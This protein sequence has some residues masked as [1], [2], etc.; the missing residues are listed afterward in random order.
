MPNYYSAGV[1]TNEQDRS[2]VAT[3]ASTSIAAIAVYA[4]QGPINEAV[5]VTNTQDYISKFGKP[6]TTNGYSAYAALMFLERS[7]ALYVTRVVGGSYA[8]AGNIITIGTGGSDGVITANTGVGSAT[9]TTFNAFTSAI[10][11]Y[12]YA[13]GPGAIGNNLRFDIQS[14]NLPV[15]TGI[16]STTTTTGGTLATGTK[17]YRVS[18]VGP[19]G[20]TLASTAHVTA[21]LTTAT[22][23]VTLTIPNIPN[24]VGYR[25]YGRTAGSES[26]LTTVSASTGSNTE[27]L[28]YD[29][30][31][32]PVAPLA[33][34]IV[35]YTRSDIFNI[36]VFDSVVSSSTPVESFEVSL[37]KQVDGYGVQIYAETRVN[38]ESNYVRIATNPLYTG[39][40]YFYPT[41][42]STLY[43]FSGGNDGSAYSSLTDGNYST[44]LNVFRD[45]EQLD[46]NILIEGGRGSTGYQQELVKLASSRKDCFAILDVP[47]A[48]QSAVKA[49][50]Y[51][52][53]T[54]ATNNN[55]AGL[56]TPDV[57]IS[58]VYGN[59][60][61]LYVPPSGH[62][63]GV[64]A[65]T[66]AVAETWF[67]P[68]GLNRGNL[69]VL[70]VRYKYNQA[71]RDMLAKAQINMIRAM[72]GLGIAV[73]GDSTLQT[74]LSAFSYVGVR[75]MFDFIAKT[76][77]QAL[78]FSVFEP[79]DS[80]L[81]ASIT[82]LVSNILSGIQ[83]KRGISDY[84]VV[85]NP[86]PAQ[87]AQG[88][89][90]VDVY[91]RPV[92]STRVI[93]VTLVATA[94]GVSVSEAITG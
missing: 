55:R 26:Y 73:W 83:S 89:L 60:G 76:A 45:P 54:L 1:Y 15:P 51:R 40:K 93:A 30:S 24:A 12:V 44:A 4:Q 79:N 33:T 36:R 39:V 25:I 27:F 52:T 32:T 67:S 28:D 84:Q 53:L 3:P 78:Q 91:L 11:F 72:P 80:I 64:F 86:T 48:Y 68:A 75:R 85:V 70:G 59:G 77:S 37:N 19:L 46:I 69:D 63:A 65:H 87:I 57:L 62:L 7:N 13:M 82:N 56:Y 92:L 61:T 34:A 20:E 35:D 18:A 88:V 41:A 21:S 50:E 16:T 66:D 42:I 47:S 6:D 2:Q 23:T 74:K 9:P 10:P 31:L 8:Y 94:Q 81:R 29:G 90:T 49:S 14:N 58:D 43:A 5:F 17:S 22:S 71:E 38:N